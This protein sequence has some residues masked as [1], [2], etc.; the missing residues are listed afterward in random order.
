MQETPQEE[1]QDLQQT[2]FPEHVLPPRVIGYDG[3][4]SLDRLLRQRII[5]P[6]IHS[7]VALDTQDAYILSSAIAAE[8]DEIWTSDERFRKQIN[9]LR[10]HGES[11]L[12]TQL[13]DAAPELFPNGIVIPKAPR[14][15]DFKP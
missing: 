11:K 10:N 3:P 8:V 14:R 5:M 2:I 1:Y 13:K 4:D 15:K 12:S 7:Y 6:N 9:T